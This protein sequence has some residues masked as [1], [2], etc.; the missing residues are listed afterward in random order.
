MS[1]LQN[2]SLVKKIRLIQWSAVDLDQNIGGGKGRGRGRGLGGFV[3]NI[4]KMVVLC[5]KH[6][7]AFF[8]VSVCMLSFFFDSSDH[9]ACG[10][11]LV[12]VIISVVNTLIK[13]KSDIL[14]LFIQ[15]R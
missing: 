5:L 11:T 13:T 2:L 7:L 3:K 10:K 12:H 4:K 6:S 1:P 9:T 15:L 8:S 14:H